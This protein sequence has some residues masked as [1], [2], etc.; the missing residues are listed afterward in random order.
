MDI[1][2]FVQ[3]IVDCLP[4]PNYLMQARPCGTEMNV[5]GW[6]KYTQVI[7]ASDPNLIAQI[8][9]GFPAGIDKAQLPSVPFTNHK[10]AIN[11][12]TVVD[13]YIVKHV[14][15][16]AIIGPFEVNPLPVPIVVSPLQ[17]ARSASGKLRVVVDMSYGRPSVN[18]LISGDW[19]AF[20]GYFG[21]FNLPSSDSLAAEIVAAGPGCLMFKADMAAFYKQLKADPAD[22]PY[23]GFTWRS[24]IFLDAT[25]PFGMRSSALSA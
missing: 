23:L 24:Q 5:D 13:E 6:K 4:G 8:E 20:P 17:V 2:Q 10:S 15:S 25:L 11:N 14:K 21:D 18:D 19:G 3:F 16:G 1:D 22:I 12:Y 7:E 9:F